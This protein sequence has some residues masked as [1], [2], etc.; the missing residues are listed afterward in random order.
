VIR[1]IPVHKLVPGMY[2][3]DL[4]RSWLEHSFWRRRFPVRD[5]AMVR[6]LIEEGVTEVSIDTARGADIPAPPEPRLVLAASTFVSRGERLRGKPSTLSLGEERRR[7]ALLL[8]EANGTLRELMVDARL[9]R[10]VDIGRLEPF[11]E[12][13]IESVLRN[14]DALPPL[15]RLKLQGSYATEHAL[16]TT[17]LVVALGRQQGLE[18]AELERLAMGT[19]LKDVG[20]AAL[21]AKLV[22]K[23][24]RLSLDE[25]DRCAVSTAI[26]EIHVGHGVSGT[27][28]MPVAVAVRP[29]K[30]D[31]AKQ[32]PTH[33]DRNLF[34]GRVKEIAYFG[35]Y[36]NYIV[37]TPQGTRVKITEPNGSRHEL[38]DI[39]WE[40][41]VFFWWDDTDAV[42][43]R[44]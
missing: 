21:D 18:Q 22:S 42:V 6:R 36:N 30:V 27:V 5:E 40:D 26:G 25:P 33:V 16:A 35:S 12:R 11:A 4:H 29:E 39:T 19:L 44:D 23:P 8:R 32:R 2:V 20:H 13:M 7:A 10:V 15:S 41:E 43:L 24:G 17:A 34:A 38:L 31:I 14:P 28:D 1:K 37:V 3:V 9:G